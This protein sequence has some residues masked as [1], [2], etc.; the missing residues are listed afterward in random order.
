VEYFKK[1]SG[2]YPDMWFKI[3]IKGEQA[4]K[5][6]LSMLRAAMNIEYVQQIG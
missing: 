3:N 6:L 2:K 4:Y 1:V 5:N